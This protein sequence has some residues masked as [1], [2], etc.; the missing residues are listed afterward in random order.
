MQPDQPLLFKDDELVPR[1]LIVDD[2]PAIHQDF[3]LVLSQDDVPDPDFEA[4]Q[5]RIYGEPRPTNCASQSFRLEHALSG[6]EGVERV[7]KSCL[8]GHPYQLAF[9]DIRMPGIDG[10]ETIKRIWR[11]DPRVQIVICTAYADYSQGDLV[12][13]LGRTDQLLV[14]KKPFDNIE[15]TQMTRTL[16]AKWFLARQAAAKLEE[17]ELL[18]SRRTRKIL[19]LQWQTSESVREPGQITLSAGS[20]ESAAAPELK[21]EADEEA[22]SEEGAFPLLLLITQDCELV[23]SIKQELIAGYRLV[24]AR[25]EKQ[26]L[27]TARNLVPDLIIADLNE[28]ALTGIE[29]C[30]EL[31]VNPL[32]NHVP[33][34]FLLT[35]DSGSSLW[36]ALQAEGDNYHLRTKP[37]DLSLL[38]SQV[39]YLIESRRRLRLHL[40]CDVGLQ[41]REIAADQWDARFLKKIIEVVEQHLSDSEFNVDTLAKS[42]GVSRR[43]LFR[44]VQAISCLTPKGIIRL[45]RLKRAAELLESSQM[46]VL[47]ITYAVGFGD[48]RTFRNL[49]RKEYGLLPSEYADRLVP[50]KFPQS[51]MF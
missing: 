29:F 10:I 36:E 35:S 1:I 25:D 51:K 2:N 32:I 42:A 27:E 3:V 12:E 7:K 18:V 16:T 40:S 28:P 45:A 22:E 20:M 44:K 48:V 4:D 30:R 11:I 39:N 23:I 47:E 21:P 26:G 46:T 33:V 37:F 8:E 13:R 34:L 19:E 9:V 43:Q 24:E 31:K 50:Q 38:K 15:V 6:L 5:Q 49:F 41:P 17:L 14:L